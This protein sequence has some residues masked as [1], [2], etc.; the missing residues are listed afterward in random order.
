ML[1]PHSRY[2]LGCAAKIACPMRPGKKFLETESWQRVGSAPGPPA[3]N[4]QPLTPPQRPK[5]L[6]FGEWHW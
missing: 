3:P 6:G 1:A 5:K 4:N 2:K